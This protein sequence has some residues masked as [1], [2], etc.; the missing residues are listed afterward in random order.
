[1]EK[2]LYK[3]CLENSGSLIEKRIPESEGNCLT[4]SVYGYSEEG[5]EG[6]FAIRETKEEAIN[7]LKEALTKEIA[8]KEED[9]VNLKKR[10]ERLTNI[11]VYNPDSCAHKSE[12]QSFL[13]DFYGLRDITK[14]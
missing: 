3:I 10:L 8:Y 5:S 4:D 9:L 13:R 2:E 1:M 12:N 11:V 14:K 6:I 7:A